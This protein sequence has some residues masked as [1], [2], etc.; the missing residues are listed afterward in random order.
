MKQNN[1]LKYMFP[2]YNFYQKN[3]NIYIEENFLNDF[4]IEN[5]RDFG[6]KNVYLK[7][8]PD[9]NLITKK[10]QH[11]HIKLFNHNKWFSPSRIKLALDEPFKILVKELLPKKI[12]HNGISKLVCDKGNEFENY[13][14]DE[15]D[16][17]L[18]KLNPKYNLTKLCEGHASLYNYELLRESYQAI[19]NGDEVIYQPI[20]FDNDTKLWGVPDFLIRSDIFCELF[21]NNKKY[22]ERYKNA[23]NSFNKPFYIVIDVKLANCTLLRNG[24]LNNSKSV[25]L[26]KIQVY[27]YHKIL[28]KIQGEILNTNYGFILGG[29][30]IYQKK[31]YHG[32]DYLG[33]IEIDKRKFENDINTGVNIIKEIRLKNNF[34]ELIDDTKFHPKRCRTEYYP[35]TDDCYTDIRTELGFV[36][37]VKFNVNDNNIDNIK[38]ELKKYK[39]VYVDFETLNLKLNLSPQEYQEKINEYNSQVCQIGLVIENNN[40]IEYHSFFAEERND[41]KIKD[42]LNKFVNYLAEIEKDNKKPLGIISWG[43]L[44]KSCYSEMSKKFNLPSLNIIDLLGMIKKNK[45]FDESMSLSLKKLIPMLKEKYPE[46]FLNDYQN[47]EVENGMDAFVELYN[48]YQKKDEKIKANIEKYNF[49]DCIVMKQIVE[50]LFKY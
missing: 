25:Y 15:L 41:E 13:I 10:R 48:Y 6:Y 16:K 31:N 45:I 5:L 28:S 47:L 34:R 33:T 40:K 12:T 22:I 14:V 30:T 49:I 37:Q 43:N 35:K 44:E 23:K 9:N 17:K 50:W 38:K 29:K 46:D 11:N 20:L 26:N 4:S 2:K 7:S 1:F 19:E 3:N 8:K 24:L 36:N 18:K 32:I 21:P 42:N 27:I 39:L